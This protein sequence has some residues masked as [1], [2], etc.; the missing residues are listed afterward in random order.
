MNPRLALAVL[1]SVLPNALWADT[2][3]WQG[4]MKS[5]GDTVSELLPELV[6]NKGNPETIEKGAKAL[7]ELSHDLKVGHHKQKLVPPADN[8]PTIGFL[9]E[10]FSDQTRR[11]YSAIKQG[12]VEYGKDLLRSVTSYCI[13]CHSRND[14]GPAFSAVPTT[15]K[16]N[17][18]SKEEKAALYVALRQFDKGLAEYRQLISDQE[19][20][21]NRP[22]D[23]ERNLRQALAIAVRVKHDPKLSSEII[24]SALQSPELPVFQRT[25]LSQWQKAVE[26]WKKEPTLKVNTEVGLTLEMRRLFREANSGQQRML[27]DHSAEIQFLRASTAA[28][29]VLRVARDPKT[30]AEALMVA[31]K[32][33]ES[34]VNPLFWP[35]HEFFYE[36]CVRQLP[37]SD[38]A[39]ACYSSYV[40]S[41]YFGYTGSAGTSIP[42][43]VRQLLSRLGKLA[44]PKQ[45]KSKD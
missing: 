18:L 7:S 27:D 40:K 25:K 38:L 34:L 35:M 14:S 1:L 32:S 11:A 16:V 22:F 6:S 31:G 21:K 15:E 9:A 26:A 5:L 17:G 28:H 13:T 39:Q 23:W 33:Y 44:G 30:V 24:A 29:E 12:Q 41:V 8:D 20:I 37:H 42:E 4:K 2:P 36:A 3:N 45:P 43:D 19:L 10:Q